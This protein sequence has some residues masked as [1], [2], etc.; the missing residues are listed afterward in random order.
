[1]KRLE[2]GAALIL[3]LMMLSF[4]AALGAAILASTTMD[5]WLVDN[6]R[7][8]IQALYLA[9]SGIEQARDLLR[10]AGPSNSQ[11]FLVGSGAG[12]TYRVSLRSGGSA[13][14]YIL[15]SVAEAGNSRQTIEAIVRK[16]G[17]PADPLDP[18]LSTVAGLE[19]LA[20]AITKNA[21]D[22]FPAGSVIGNYGSV[23]EHR[24]AVVLGD[25]TVGPGTGYGLLLVT[26]QLRLSGGVGWTGLIVVI[27]QGTVIRDPDAMVQIVGGIF[28]ARTRDITEQLLSTPASVNFEVTDQD[29]IVQSNS[30]FPY[31]LVSIREN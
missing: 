13:D 15:R 26:G 7:T 4:L 30:A 12:G 22:V 10:T 16:G 11:P 25:A 17:F 6:Y 9:E 1:M 21:I 14:V 19:R 5:I 8:R 3:T 18:R 24:V 29:A 2:R 28:S 31:G 23:M 27:G 20:S